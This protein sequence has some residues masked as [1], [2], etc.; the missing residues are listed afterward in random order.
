MSLSSRLRVSKDEVVAEYG[1]VTANHPLSS[2]AGLEML[3]KGG[4]AVDAAVATG[5]TA[6]VVEPMMTTIGGCGFMLVH[7]AQE[8]KSVV[9]EF[10]PRAPGAAGPEMYTVEDSAILDIGLQSVANSENIIG[11]KSASV[12]G[13][14]AGFCMAHS[15]YGSLPLEQVMEPAIHHAEQGFEVGLVHGGMSIADEMERLARYPGISAL[16][17]NGGFPPTVGSRLVQKDLGQTLRA[18]AK[19]GAKAFYRRRHCGRHSQRCAIERGPPV[20]RRPGELSGGGS[21][22]G[23]DYLSGTHGA[24]GEGGERWDDGT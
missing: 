18:V 19:S 10:S 22:A 17:L 20:Q 16:L 8:G 7:L 6:C 2:E 3:K 14:V 9:I 11:P 24:R 15:K 13:T 4:N 1:V 5:F 23:V 12:P 21:R